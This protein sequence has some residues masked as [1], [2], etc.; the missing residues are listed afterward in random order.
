M[1]ERDEYFKK[2]YERK[3]S[4]NAS[5]EYLNYIYALSFIKGS[6]NAHLKSIRD[7]FKW[8]ELITNNSDINPDKALK[9]A[10]GKSWVDGFNFCFKN[11]DKIYNLREKEQEAGNE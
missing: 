10:L 8:Y 6:N 7:L 11:M 5:Q 1:S 2:E 3:V 9:I 4:S